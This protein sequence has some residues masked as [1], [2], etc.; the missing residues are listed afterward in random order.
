MNQLC[1]HNVIGSYIIEAECRGGKTVLFQRT[2]LHIGHIGE[3]VDQHWFKTEIVPM[4][5]VNEV[6]T[7]HDE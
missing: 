5:D 3:I 1:I 7:L 2:I 6:L 4:A